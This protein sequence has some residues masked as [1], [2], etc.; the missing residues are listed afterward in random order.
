MIRV[1]M[2]GNLGANAECK[3]EYLCQFGLLGSI[4]MQNIF[5][6]QNPTVELANNGTEETKGTPVF[7]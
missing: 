5:G 2:I 4:Y 7:K 3:S 1:Q 6:V